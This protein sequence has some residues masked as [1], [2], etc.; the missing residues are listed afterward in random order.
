MG[1]GTLLSLAWAELSCSDSLQENVMIVNCFKL[2]ARL[3][4]L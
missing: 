4:G 3:E 1:P 2:L